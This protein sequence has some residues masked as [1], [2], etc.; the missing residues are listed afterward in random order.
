MLGLGWTEILIIGLVGL[1]IIG[2]QQLP[3][4][5]RGFAKFVRQLKDMREEWTKA[6]REDKSLQEI[7]RSVNEVK[8]SVSRS[9]H[10]TD[11]ATLDESTES[12]KPGEK[13]DEHK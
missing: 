11:D 12:Y 8:D 1:L 4:V 7:Q 5:L 9:N 2:P 6:V 13:P 3:E 10:P